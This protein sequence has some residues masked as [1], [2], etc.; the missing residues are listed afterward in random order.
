MTQGTI[1][2]MATD[3]ATEGNNSPENV[4]DFAQTKKTEDEASLFDN[5]DTCGKDEPKVD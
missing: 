4:A 5:D 1:L 3:G 2:G